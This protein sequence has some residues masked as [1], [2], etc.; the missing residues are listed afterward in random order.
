MNFAFALSPYYVNI[1][2]RKLS[3]DPHKIAVDKA[4]Q[5]VLL[6]FYFLPPKAY[7]FYRY[8]AATYRNP[9]EKEISKVLQRKA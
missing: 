1:S 5:R 7:L 8:R 4:H 9:A 3:S 6:F 2:V